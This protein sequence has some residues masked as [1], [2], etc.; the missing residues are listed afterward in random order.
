MTT[1]TRTPAQPQAATAGREP[2]TERHAALQLAGEVELRRLQAAHPR[3][4]AHIGTKWQPTEAVSVDTASGAYWHRNPRLYLDGD[5][6][7]LQAVLLAKLQQRQPGRIRGA[8]LAGAMGL[9]LAGVLFIGLST[10]F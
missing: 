5:S 2:R 10:G 8:L 7:T 1:P 6:T 4:V 9:A 3:A